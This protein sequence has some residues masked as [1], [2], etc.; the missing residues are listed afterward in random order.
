MT[1][2][3]FQERIFSIF[4]N[5]KSK[6]VDSRT[7]SIIPVVREKQTIAFLE[8]LTIDDIGNPNSVVLLS[9]WRKENEWWFP[10][11]FEVRDE[12]TKKWLED[13]VIKNESRLLFWIKTKEGTPVGHIGLYRINPADFSCEIDNVL[14]GVSDAP[15]GIMTDALLVLMDW[16]FSVLG[17]RALELEV[18]A[19]N[20]RALVLYQRCGLV[21]TKKIPLKRVEETHEVR[22]ERMPDGV[23][24]ERYFLRMRIEPSVS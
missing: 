9:K 21:V 13:Q 2:K 11:Q 6:I 14:R 7:A 10:A 3:E 18:F 1:P 4:H 24:G 16:A 15:K 8:P 19:D 5:L 12:R 20:Q 23:D 22:W 17:S